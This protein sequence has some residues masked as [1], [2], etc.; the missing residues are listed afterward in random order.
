M[1]VLLTPLGYSLAEGHDVLLIYDE[2]RFFLDE[3]LLDFLLETVYSTSTK[4][5]E[6]LLC[7]ARQ[8]NPSWSSSFITYHLLWLTKQG[9]LTFAF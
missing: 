5:I 9:F 1:K 6:E 7:D 3:D 4:T 2:L 8:Q